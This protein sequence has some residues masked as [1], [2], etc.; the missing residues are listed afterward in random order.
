MGLFADHPDTVECSA[1]AEPHIPIA[2]KHRIE[3]DRAGLR[4]A[5]RD[6]VEEGVL[7]ARAILV[8]DTTDPR[9]IP[10]LREAI[11]RELRRPP[12]EEN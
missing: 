4:L 5:A 3:Q 2:K 12:R 1:W 7:Y 11:N 8:R 6:I 10:L 9:L